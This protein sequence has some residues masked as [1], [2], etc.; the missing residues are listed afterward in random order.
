[1]IIAFSY[2]LYAVLQ[3][4][5]LLNRRG[6]AERNRVLIVLEFSKLKTLVRNRTVTM[7]GMGRR[8]PSYSA[9]N[10]RM[11]DETQKSLVSLSFE[12]HPL[13]WLG[14]CAFINTFR[15]STKSAIIVPTSHNLNYN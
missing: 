3:S 14:S 9:Y 13:F 4:Y 2:K 6:A 10:E 12:G 8:P 11:W 15:P 1:M 7:S 5:T